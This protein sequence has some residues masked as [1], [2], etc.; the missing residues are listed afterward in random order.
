[1]F[2]RKFY[3]AAELLF[4][5]F[6]RVMNSITIDIWSVSVSFV[7]PIPFIDGILILFMTW[8]V[9]NLAL[10]QLPRLNYYNN[11]IS[12]NVHTWKNN[13]TLNKIIHWLT[14]A[15]KSSPRH[16]FRSPWSTEAL[17]TLHTHTT[18]ARV[19]GA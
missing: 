14:K 4:K 3:Y 11:I 8:L 5:D 18:E 9:N 16:H 1:M 15:E 12:W 17:L 13:N 6:C 7:V 10:V 2:K 19:G